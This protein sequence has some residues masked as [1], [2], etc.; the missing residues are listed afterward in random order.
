MH[1]AHLQDLKNNRSQTFAGPSLEDVM[2]QV[3]EFGEEEGIDPDDKNYPVSLSE[4]HTYA[5]EIAESLAEGRIND[6]IQAVKLGHIHDI[7]SWCY[8]PDSY[9]AGKDNAKDALTEL[10][11][12]ADKFEAECYEALRD[13]FDEDAFDEDDEDAYDEL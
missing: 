10:G 7:G 12:D 13:E 4:I 3:F 8:N 5:E 6:Y 9:E 1:I 2:G 11:I